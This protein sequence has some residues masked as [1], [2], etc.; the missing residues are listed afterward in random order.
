MLDARLRPPPW[1]ALEAADPRAA[2]RWYALFLT[3]TLVALGAFLVLRLRSDLRSAIDREVRASSSAIRQTYAARASAASARSAPRRCAQ[4]LRGADP[5]TRRAGDRVLRRGHRPGPDAAS[6]AQMAAMPAAGA[7]ADVD[8]GDR[9]QPF[10]VTSAPVAVHGQRAV[11]GRRRVAAGR[12]RGGAQDPGPAADRRADRAAATAAAAWLLLRK[13]AAAGGADASEGGDDRDRPARRAACRRRTPTTSSVS[14]PQRSTRCSTGSRRACWPGG[15][16]S[17][18]PRTSCARRWRR[19]APS[20]TSASETEPAPT[21]SGRC[22]P[23][24]AM[25]STG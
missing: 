1:R 5:R 7:A 11:A 19:C 14:W 2:D 6:G 17:P 15:S 23:A 24:C 20:S 13:S 16:S 8:L 10:R 25:T 22:W 4:R 18:T 3:A 12:R 21:P 9:G